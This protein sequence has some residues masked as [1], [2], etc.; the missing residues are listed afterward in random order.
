MSGKPTRPGF[1]TVTPYLIVR[2]LEPM[3]DFFKQAFGATEHFRATGSAGGT[4]LEMRIGDSM[5][6]AVTVYAAVWPILIN[7]IDGVRHIEDVLI[8]TGRTFGLNRR[9][10][11]RHV[12]LPAAVWVSSMLG[13]RSR[14]VECSAGSIPA[15]SLNPP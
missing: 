11:L 3:I 14:L 15:T 13:P 5:I 10:I 7:T 9:K 8:Q 6:V 4:H 12:V 2:E 1:H